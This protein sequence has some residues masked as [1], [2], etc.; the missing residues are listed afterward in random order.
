MTLSC[1]VEVGANLSLTQSSWERSLSTGTITLAV[2]N[3]EFGISISPEY[4]KRLSFH[5]P[6]PQNVTVVLQDVGFSDSGV[7][8]CKVATF[9]LG[10]T[11]A[12]TH[13]SIMVKPEVYVSAGSAPLLDGGNESLVATCIAERA[14][15]PAN[16][17]WETELFGRSQAHQQ[18]EPNGTTTS[19]VR[20]LWRPTRRAQDH[21]LTCVVQHPALPTEFRIPYQLNVQYAPEVTVARSNGE[22]YAG[23]E[24]AQLQCQANANPP[25]HY[26]H[27]SRLDGPMPEGVEVL[28]NTLLFTLPLHQNDS[29]VYRCEV[30]NDI[31]QKSRET[32]IWIQEPPPTTATTS[33]T[34]A[35]IL[36]GNDFSNTAPANRR[37]Q[38]SSP[39]LGSL[40]DSSLGAI[41]GG[42]VGGILLLVLILVLGGVCYMRQRRTFRGDYYT[43]QYLGPAD[44]QKEPQLDMLQPHEL[45]EVYGR[46]GP[47]QDSPDLK[48]K[49]CADI[50]HSEYDTERKDREDWGDGMCNSRRIHREEVYY[51]NHHSPHSI[52]SREMPMHLSSVNNG[53]PYLSEDFYDNGIDS[54]YVSHL[55]GSVISRREWYV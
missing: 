54:E 20:Y 43:K 36:P 26:W 15:P 22:W 24:N 52:H 28:N 34:P 3:P 50:V 48:P 19:Q 35:L 44:M 12:S 51:P 2:F 46:G 49:S 42:A 6:S 53:S 31:A 13:V 8:T 33:T 45:Q 1:L 18:A 55:D 27:W 11:Q 32:R 25:V 47:P 39:T 23:R 41:V 9:P 4:R 37:F 14:R 16:V 29:G 21:P 40:P 17:S 10:N 5:S 30:A 7:Y 38:V